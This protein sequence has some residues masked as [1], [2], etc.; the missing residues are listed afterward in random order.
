MSSFQVRL[1]KQEHGWDWDEFVT[2]IFWLMD[3][4]EYPEASLDE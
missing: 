1:A 2:Y 3:I 4:G